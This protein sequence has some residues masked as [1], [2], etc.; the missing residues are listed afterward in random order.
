MKK[1]LLILLSV[2]AALCFVIL[3]SAWWV[4]RPLPT[5]KRSAQADQLAHAMQ[6]AIDIQAWKRTGAIRWIFRDR[7]HHLW[8]RQRHYSQVRWKSGSNTIVAQL[9]LGSLARP[10]TPNGMAKIN[11]RELHGQDLQ[12]ILTK[13]YQYWCNDSYWLNPIE[14]VF[15]KGVSRRI[16]QDG[17]KTMLMISFSK[18]GVTPGDR[19][20]Y[21]LNAQGLPLSWRMWV[22]ILP[23]GG[24]YASFSGWKTLSTGARVS[25]KHKIGPLTLT[26]KQVQAAKNIHKL[27]GQDPFSWLEGKPRKTMKHT[28]TKRKVSTRPTSKKGRSGP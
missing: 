11:Q 21:T 8:D 6:R 13:A 3:F 7:H 15:D 16:V 10:N 19:Y 1:V 27:V 25:T 4:H 22:S 23:V 12:E 24:V 17:A 28:S 14:K 20:L 9:N 5:S 26:L 2:F 18:G